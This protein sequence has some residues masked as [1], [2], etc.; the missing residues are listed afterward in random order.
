MNQLIQL[1]KTLE[2]ANVHVLVVG[3]S[4]LVLEAHVVASVY[5]LKVRVHSV[6]TASEMVLILTP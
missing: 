6:V 2:L 4:I 5:V 1:R 3:L